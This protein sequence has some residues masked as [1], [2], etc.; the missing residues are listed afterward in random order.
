MVDERKMSPRGRCTFLLQLCTNIG[1]QFCSAS[2]VKRRE[3][4][5]IKECIDS[6][7]VAY[8]WQSQC[9]RQQRKKMKANSESVQIRPHS[10]ST[11]NASGSGA[12]QIERQEQIEYGRTRAAVAMQERISAK[13][14]ESQKQIVSNTAA[15]TPQSQC[16]QQR[17]GRN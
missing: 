7:T 15:H 1:Y 8:A 16:K 17:R 3:K 10:R 5:E 11:C 14:T 9:K 2:N 12:K 6:N 4:I 13:K